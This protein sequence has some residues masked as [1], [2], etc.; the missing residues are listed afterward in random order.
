MSETKATVLLQH[1]LKQLKLP[2]FLREYEKLAAV[3]QQ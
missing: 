2:S 3:C 1:H